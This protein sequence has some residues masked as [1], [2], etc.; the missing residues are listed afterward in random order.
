MFLPGMVP[1]PG[2]E[3]LQTRPNIFNMIRGSKIPSIMD[4]ERMSVPEEM[5]DTMATF[6]TVMEDERALG[7]HMGEKETIRPLLLTRFRDTDD[8]FVCGSFGDTDRDHLI[9]V[10]PL[11]EPGFIY[12][13]QSLQLGAFIH[14][15]G[16]EQAEIPSNGGSGE[17]RDFHDGSKSHLFLP[18]EEEQIEILI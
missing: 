11:A 12:F 9:P 8:G 15:R 2:N 6:P 7:L 4:M 3:T 17:A 5:I 1:C 14:E 18:A 13:N 10:T 16:S